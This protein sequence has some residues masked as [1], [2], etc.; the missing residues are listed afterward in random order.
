LKASQVSKPLTP[1][2]LEAL[3]HLDTFIGPEP[4]RVLARCLHMPP[5]RL[6]SRVWRLRLRL[7]GLADKPD[8][9]AYCIT[10]AGRDYLASL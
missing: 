4:M 10:P 8:D 1:A 6:A 5:Q 7:R 9:E 2:L 3:R